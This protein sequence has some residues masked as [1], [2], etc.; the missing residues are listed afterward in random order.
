MRIH[1]IEQNKRIQHLLAMTKPVKQEV[2]YLTDYTP[3]SITHDTIVGGGVQ[4]MAD[5]ILKVKSKQQGQGQGQQPSALAVQDTDIQNELKFKDEKIELMQKQ[6]DNLRKQLLEQ[7]KIH[8]SEVKAY[9]EDR[10]LREND[11]R[12][13]EEEHRSALNTIVQG[14]RDLENRYARTTKDLLECRQHLALQQRQYNEKLAE[15]E[16][17][18]A[19][20]RHELNIARDGIQRRTTEDMENMR[21]KQQQA[22]ADLEILKNQYDTA[23]Q[24]YE[25][26]IAYLTDRLNTL[27]QKYDTL[28]ERRQLEYE[29]FST[30]YRQ[31][32]ERVRQLE[33]VIVA[34][35]SQIQPY[36]DEHHHRHP[37]YDDR[38][39]NKFLE[40]DDEFQELLKALSVV[41]QRLQLATT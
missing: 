16:H 19:K 17:E 14:V 2:T 37:Q 36:I 7:D 11:I 10:K 30:D 6:I 21:N 29:G 22:E 4:S 3:K 38:L 27:K 33:S 32:R 40:I 18:A 34:I 28:Y 13:R 5:K 8:R 9:A 24:L 31:I 23:Q 35:K 26:R 20:L 15:K 12:H 25:K 41:A 1:E 39:S